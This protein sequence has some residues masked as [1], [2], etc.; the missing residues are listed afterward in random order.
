[1]QIRRVCTPLPCVPCVAARRSKEAL[2]QLDKL[3]QNKKLK[4]ERSSEVEEPALKKKSKAERKAEAEPKAQ[5][6]QPSEK[7]KEAPKNS[8]KVKTLAHLRCAFFSPSPSLPWRHVQRF[9]PKFRKLIV[10]ITPIFPH[11]RSVALSSPT[12][13]HSDLVLALNTLALVAFEECHFEYRAIANAVAHT[14]E[15][16]FSHLRHYY[17]WRLCWGS[18]DCGGG[19]SALGRGG[20]PAIGTIDGN[21][22]RGSLNDVSRGVKFDSHALHGPG[23]WDGTCIALVYHSHAAAQEVTSEEQQDIR[24][25]GFPIAA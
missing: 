7:P 17:R 13:H 2:A 24:Q 10:D 8:P 11:Y 1:M 6:S 23:P 19:G 12:M 5:P 20:L 18:V 14:H 16:S 4:A 9:G 25:M 22:V 15:L 3:K 21:Q